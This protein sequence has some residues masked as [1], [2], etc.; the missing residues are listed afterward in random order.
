VG[1]VPRRTGSA[2]IKFLSSIISWAI[3]NGELGDRTYHE[4]PIK[5]KV[6]QI[7]QDSSEM[8]K[9]V[10]MARSMSIAH[11]GLGARVG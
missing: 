10:K 1:Q 9:M 6:G 7:P 8:E 11:Y 4:I 2:W 5:I 3:N